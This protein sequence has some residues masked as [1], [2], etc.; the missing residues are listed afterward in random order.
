MKNCR[1]LVKLEEEIKK[2]TKC[3][4]H[5]S[6]KNAVPGEGNPEA[7][8]MFIGEAPGRN[9]D[10]EGRPFVGAAG[11]LLTNLI[12]NIGLRREDV[13]I[14]NV[15]KCR[16]PN[17]RDPKPEEIKA[18]SPYLDRQINCIAPRIIV[19]LGR[20]S[21]KYLLEKNG[22]NF[23][24]ILKIH[25]KIYNIK[26]GYIDIKLI[27][28]LHPAAALYNPRFVKILEEDFNRIK[29]EIRKIGKEEEKIGLEKF[30]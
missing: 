21:T 13:Y 5:A 3:P 16:P 29:N 12:E 6:R 25:G 15:V 2:C 22:Y 4:L 28:T 27:P 8:I 30:F 9:E 1:E 19:T 10:L 7:I 11:R 26:I 14:T 20:H 17:N 24:S 18:C 23:R